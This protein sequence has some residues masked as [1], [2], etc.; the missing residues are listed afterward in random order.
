M[1]DKESKE[2]ASTDIM[3]KVLSECQKQGLLAGKNSDTV[4]GFNNIITLSPPFVT[5][6]KEID[7]IV[8][9]LDQALERLAAADK[10]NIGGRI[11]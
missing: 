3:L 2:P 7:F 11:G 8:D 10:V 4:P 9:T 5:S 6:E 1:E